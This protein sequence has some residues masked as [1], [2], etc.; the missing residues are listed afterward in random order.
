LKRHFQVIF[1]ALLT[2]L[3]IVDLLLMGL[4]IA[5]LTV[6]IKSGSVYNIGNY[7][8]VIALLILIDFIVFRIRMDKLNRNIGSFIRDNWAYIVSIIPL[9]FICFN[10]F[11][12]FSFVYI[13]VL[14]IILRFYALY[15]LLQITR[16]EVHKYPSKTK[17]DYA[18]FVLLLVLVFGSFLF[19]LVENGV[20]PEVPTY[21][22]A[23]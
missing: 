8:L 13:I 17:L 10:I 19:F 23:M 21:E 1:E 2:V 20:N 12:F 3:I 7:D 14:I 6:G 16:R 22:S 4:M 18:T 5:G 15:K 11:H 9:S